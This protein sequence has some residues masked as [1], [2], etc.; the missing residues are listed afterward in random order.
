MFD[1]NSRARHLT[2]GALV[3]VA[4]VTV[5]ACAHTQQAS[6]ADSASPRGRGDWQGSHMRHRSGPRGDRM[7]AGMNLTKDQHAQIAL[8]HDRY[9]L[10]ADSMRAGGMAHDSTARAAHRAV[11]MQEMSE[12]R[13][14]LNPD[15]QKQF[16][17][18][19]AKMRE[20]HEQHGDRDGHGDHD[21]HD[22]PPPDN[23]GGNPPP[24]PTS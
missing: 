7:F 3:C 21:G 15:Q 12:I 5:A 24:P 9:R 20:R 13:S 17:E 19:V 18:K 22:G 14:V 16:D 1:L 4:A 23:S 10:K 6:P 11:M 8:I 2:L